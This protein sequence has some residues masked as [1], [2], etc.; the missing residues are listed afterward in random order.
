MINSIWYRL[1]NA[2]STFAGEQKDSVKLFC[3]AYMN[4][5]QMRLIMAGILLLVLSGIGN[6]A[7]AFTTTYYY[8][9]S[10]TA[11]TG[12]NY[13]TGATPTGI[14]GS[15]T[16]SSASATG[17]T[18]STVQW[19]W[20]YNTT[21]ATGTLTGATLAFTGV[22]YTPTVTT[23]NPANLPAASIST[24]TP[25]TY[26][27]F[28]YVTSSGG[29]TAAGPLYS[30]LATVNVAN[31]P[32][33]I[34]GTPIMCSGLTATLSDA[35]SGGTWT[36]SGAGATVA[37]T[38]PTTSTVT[39]VT[40]GTT[41]ISYTNAGGCS[42]TIIATVTASVAAMSGPTSVCLG[43]SITMSDAS[44]G[45]WS[46]SV[47]GVATV[48]PTGVVN[49]ISQGVT[50]IIL[51]AVGGCNASKSVTVNASPAAIAG[52]PAVCPGNTTT[53]SDAATSGT[54]SSSVPA[55]GTINAVT[56]QFGGVLTGTTVVTYNNGCGTP[57]T[58]VA[59][60][61]PLP[62]AISG[63]GSLCP[64][65]S[66]IT[67]TDA[68]TGGT[69]SSSLP[70]VATA[71]TTGPGSG[72]IVSGASGT[73]V[74][75]YTSGL[76][77][78]ASTVVTVEPLPP[79]ISGV[80]HECTSATSTLTDLVTGGTWSSSTTP[81]ATIDPTLGIVIGVTG[82]TTVITYTT[83]CGYITAIDTAI[84]S[85][86][87][88]VGTDS[89]CIGST[90]T[91]A[92]L[93]AG[94]T[95]TS[96]TPAIGTVISTSG[97]ITGI[98]A[99]KTAITYTIP[100][101]CFVSDSVR[102]MALPPAITGTT[103]ACPGTTTT[104]HD[105]STGGTWYSAQ[106]YIASVVGSTGVVTGVT[107][108]VANITYTSR[109][110]CVTNTTVTINPA[111]SA[112]IG[113][114]PTCASLLDTLYDATPGGVW[115]SGNTSVAI[116]GSSTGI[117][118]TGSGGTATIS[119][120]LPATGCFVKTSFEVFPRPVPIVTYYFLTNTFYTDTF[121]TQYQWYNTLQLAIPD[122]NTYKTAALYT[123]Y[124]WVQVTD[125][126][127]CQA[128]SPQVYYNVAMLGV[129]NEANADIHIYPNPA[130]NI[131]HIAAAIPVRAVITGADG[132]IAMEQTDAKEINISNL[133]TGIYY[134][135]LYN[136]NG[137]QVMVQKLVK[138]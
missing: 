95:W 28:L 97:V 100:A 136:D 106:T 21:G 127:G 119:Y 137:A 72:L 61:Y 6:K 91:Y 110:G 123:S 64:G 132:K 29:T 34:L 37:S 42:A 130:K 25:G 81:V 90:T 31:P 15:I 107:T 24:A 26:Y 117:V 14:T 43:S 12:A 109:S 73:T 122:A 86:T 67:L 62:A 74:I 80:L 124:Y 19:Y 52:T 89:V 99:G 16:S 55:T 84:A 125:T 71:T 9:S 17:G 96:S 135:A 68:T 41:I 13:C 27:Y 49:S 1:R 115:S 104:L 82:G 88:I 75:T 47:P 70:P 103:R 134:I 108:G 50:S 121:Y 126:N 36:T 54:W 101:G 83:G 48:S 63:P 102:V 35:T 87:P 18:S 111:P 128:S 105:A 138:E 51:T 93:P 57:A 22:A 7:S 94:G 92:S 11:G 120:T 116:V 5:K 39:G 114:N 58:V 30:N 60:V 33:A 112:I 118:T 44:S 69:W 79:A 131:V 8:P 59:T 40:P 53:L 85:P 133:A 2:I 32:T 3:S 46:S 113:E 4:T 10:A 129:G 56:G 65:G 45:T 20:Y 23:A 76:G 78:T 98:A 38:G 77:C 66:S